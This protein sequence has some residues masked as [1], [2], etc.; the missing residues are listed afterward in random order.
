LVLSHIDAH[1]E[2][3]LFFRK[4]LDKFTS[5]SFWT[6]L[7]WAEC[8]FVSFLTH[9]G[10]YKEAEHIGR[11][12]LKQGTEKLGPEHIDTL[13]YANAL[14]GSLFYQSKGDEAV[15]LLRHVLKGRE[16]SMT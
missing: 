5:D 13:A 1:E 6:A 4:Y 7:A 11:R 12:V 15:V 2:A 10:R 14:A 9:R 16:R 3:M 8:S